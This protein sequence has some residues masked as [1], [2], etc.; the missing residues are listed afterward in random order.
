MFFGIY[1][2]IRL[3]YL[4]IYDKHLTKYTF[5]SVMSQINYDFTYVMQEKWLAF[6]IEEQYCD[7]QDSYK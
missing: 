2:I 1:Y 4:E 5:S 7:F 3:F 6:Y